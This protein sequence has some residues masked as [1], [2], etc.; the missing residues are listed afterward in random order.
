VTVE[1]TSVVFERDGT[2]SLALMSALTPEGQ[3]ALATTRDP[4]AMAAMCDEPWEGTTVALQNDGT[5]NS[6]AV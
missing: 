5:T 6:L 1:A 4:S 3:R 2:P